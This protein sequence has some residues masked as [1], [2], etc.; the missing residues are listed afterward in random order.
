MSDAPMPESEIEE[1]GDADDDSA[2]DDD[3]LVEVWNRA[4]DR[5]D[6]VAMPQIELRA[7]SLEARRFVTIP[8]A[9][10]EGAWGE[11]FENSPRPE[12]DKI[13]KSL[14]KIETDYKENRVEVDFVPATDSADEQT[15]ETLDGMYRADAYHF[16]AMQAYDN[17]FQEG[18]RGGFGAWRLT[19]EYADPT[20]PD[21]D[22]QRVNPGVAI[23]DADQS[24]YFYGGVLYDK[25]DAQA[26]FIITRDLM[27]IAKA[28]W[29]D[30]N[31]A[32]WPSNQWR[33]Q[34]DWYT[35]DV[36]CIAEYYEVEDCSDRLIVLTNELTDEERR[37]FAT[38]I[39]P[40]SV[41]DMLAQGWKKR[42]RKVSRNRIRKYILNGTRV[43]KDCGYI[44]GD[45]IPIVPYYGRRDFVDNMER[46]RGHVG[47]K[48]DRQRIYNSAIANI[49]ETNSL[50]PY[51]V[52]IFAPEQMTPDLLIEW[53]RGNID[54]KPLR[55]A[56][57]LRNDDG[58]IAQAGPTGSVSA[59][60]V[61][62]GTAALVQ[63][64]AGDLQD[65]DDTADQVKANTPVAAMDLAAARVDAKSAIYIDY[66]RQSMQRCAEIY[67]GMAREV[68]F[69][70]GRKVQTQ[71]AD[72]QD[73]TAVLMEPHT[74]DNGVFTIRNDLS[75]GKYKVVATVQEA[76]TT[77]RQ[78]AVRE[79]L[80]LAEVAGKLGDQELGQ[81]QLLNAMLNI[82]GIS[83]GMTKWLRMR[84]VQAGLEEPTAEEKQQM[85][86]AA[87]QQQQ[88]SVADQALM[89]QIKKLLADAGLSEAKTQES[90]ATTVQKMAD[91]HL[92]TAQA[93]V[94]GGPDKAPEVPTGLSAANDIVDIHAKAAGADLKLAQAAHL[95]DQMGHQRIR[96]GA[97]LTQAEHDRE[98]D[99]RA[100]DRDDR[101]SNAI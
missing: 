16:K 73:G 80:N 68:N 54:R 91:A 70:E 10:W 90:Q 37:F 5:F 42:E 31:L 46:W 13:T 7:Q 60:Q 29:G 57:P 65:D 41:S 34:W 64:T 8:G 95:R 24:V 99:R 9:M 77:K 2:R 92:K 3:R 97:E 86:Q 28:K 55:L 101:A 58:T 98:M 44:A 27:S 83:P 51:E 79:S 87:Q 59:P 53:A 19:T 74:D 14:E 63:I 17:A 47:K 72:E 4:L 48:M 82:D 84:A 40:S 32:P 39:E 85:E 23:V 69:E 50:A 6:E 61:Q 76:T 11:Q 36:A 35:P 21:N 78:R 52:P 62:P 25:S 100:A 75:R 45:C 12:V 30:E 93:D 38:E 56:L 71:T 89:A 96:T 67:Q 66:F 49:V 88:P 26:A 20:D 33:W 15:A 1:G 94:V 81:A 22:H 18:I 43:L